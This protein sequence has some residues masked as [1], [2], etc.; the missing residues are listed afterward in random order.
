[1]GPG[2]RRF[3]PFAQPIFFPRIDDSHCN[4][5]HSS[6]NAADCFDN[7]YVGKKEYCAEYWLRELHEGMEKCT[8]RRDVTER[9]LKAGINSIQS[10]NLKS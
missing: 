5:I 8:G 4:R 3:D 6:L 7:D 9:L 2:D 10:I 1:M